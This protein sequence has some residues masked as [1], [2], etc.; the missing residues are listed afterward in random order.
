MRA[1]WYERQGTAT[2]VLQVGEL[3]D[4]QPGPGAHPLLRGEPRGH[5]EAPWLA[6]LVDA[7]PP[8]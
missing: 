7:V 2:E 1:V 5:E 8:G 3:P 6:G 4:P